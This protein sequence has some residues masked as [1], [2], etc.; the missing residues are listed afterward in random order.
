MNMQK[1]AC[2]FNEKETLAQVFS[3]EFCEISKNTFFHRTP[4]VAASKYEVFIFGVYFVLYCL[5]DYFFIFFISFTVVDVTFIDCW[6]C[7]MS[8]MDEFMSDLSDD[9]LHHLLRY[10]ESY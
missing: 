2:N 7:M 9:K 6:Q 3:F 10:L 4:L 1:L 8:S 5:C